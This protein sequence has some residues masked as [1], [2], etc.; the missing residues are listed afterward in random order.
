MALMKTVKYIA[1]VA[2]FWMQIG[3]LCSS[4]PM[5][6]WDSLLKSNKKFVKNSTFEKQR[7]QLKNG[8]NPPVIVLSCS[9]SRVPPELIFDKKLGSL[10]VVR[11]AGGVI[12]DV[13]VD[14]IEYAVSHFDPRVIVVLGHS[15]CAA[16]AGALKHLRKSGGVVG[17]SR[18]HLNAV[19]IPIETA[20]IESGIDIHGSGA[21]EESIK[22]HVKHAANRLISQSDAIADAVR[23]GKIAIVGAEYFLNTGNVDELFVIPNKSV[24]KKVTKTRWFGLI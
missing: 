18:K 22:T 16:V 3:I 11:V 12:D 7:A 2:V 15:G 5:A 20:I 17:K 13:V 6:E 23:D 4:S 21:L 8:Q 1:V 14:S 19:L 24:T 10:F 9:D